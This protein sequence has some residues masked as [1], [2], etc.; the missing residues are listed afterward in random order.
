MGKLWKRCQR[1]SAYVSSSSVTT[2]YGRVTVTD[3]M[4]PE[5]RIHQW[6]VN[7]VTYTVTASDLPEGSYTFDGDFET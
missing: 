5:I 7:S 3:E 6:G 1:V 4:E 2:G